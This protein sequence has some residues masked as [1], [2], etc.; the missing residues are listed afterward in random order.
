[1]KKKISS[2]ILIILYLN[3]YPQNRVPNPSFED[4]L[5]CPSVISLISYAPPWQS[6]SSVGTPD[7]F[8][9]CYN[10]LWIGVDVPNNFIGYEYA[11][12]GKAYSGILTWSGGF[13][14]NAREYIEV[15]LIDSLMTG[16]KYRVSF[17]V[18]LPDSFWYA[19]NS[20]GAYLSPTL[21]SDTTG[22]V[23]PY[24]PQIFNTSSNP[25]TNKSG[26]TMIS[27]VFT[28]V[29][30]EKY[31][32]IGNFINDMNSDSIYV[33]GGGNNVAVL[34]SYYYIDDVSVIPDSVT[35][36]N[37][38]QSM[39]N[40]VKVYPNPASDAIT[41]E[42]GQLPV[43]EKVYIELSNLEG[44]KIMSYELLWDENQKKISLAKY[45]TGMY[46]YKVISNGKM[47]SVNKLAVIRE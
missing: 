18:S 10:F 28:A 11:R 42:Y 46:L 5:H 25:L 35:G 29:G 6:A 16:I 26:W 30:G 45:P 13:V 39:L 3:V 41:V 4:T 37:G 17:F 32:T 14:V 24:S 1:M 36:M 7:Y 22:H 43:G 33:G 9:E 23:L 20:I 21:I 8:N 34:E 2:L 38:Y 31:I 15:Q 27:K 40:K 47:I 12:T 44:E 19:C